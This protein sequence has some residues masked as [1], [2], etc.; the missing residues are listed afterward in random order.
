MASTQALG[1]VTIMGR[2]YLHAASMCYRTMF[3]NV[4]LRACDA[5]FNLAEDIQG[6][7]LWIWGNFM[8]S[9]NR[10]RRN[11]APFRSFI[12]CKTGVSRNSYMQRTTEAA[13]TCLFCSQR[14]SCLGCWVAWKPDCQIHDPHRGCVFRECWQSPVMI[15]Q[16]CHS[17][18]AEGWI[19]WRRNI[20][21]LYFASWLVA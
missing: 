19:Q 18:S 10:L 16:H 5:R 2:R 11:F 6:T 3:Q 15:L 12:H 7:E 4:A 9:R 8:R 17:A 20:L 13:N 1:T 21:Q 14:L